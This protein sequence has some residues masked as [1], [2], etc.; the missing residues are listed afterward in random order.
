MHTTHSALSGAQLRS[1]FSGKT[2]L[3]A[4]DSET[5]LLALE[6]RCQ[7][8]GF[9]VEKTTHGLQTLLKVAKGNLDLL[10]LDLNLPDTTGFKVIERLTDP[11]FPP[12][13]VIIL[14]AQTDADT[15]K[16]CEDLGVPYVHK[17]DNAWTELETAIHRVFLER[18][19]DEQCQVPRRKIPHQRQ[20]YCWWTM[21]PLHLSGSRRLCANKT[22]TPSR[23]RAA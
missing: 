9:R 11:K 3:V 18:G 5:M 23:R 2:V 6:T 14:T 10:I 13:P 1:T 7:G 21:I 17:G 20:G 8:L 16:R 4:D 19:E 12:L 15:I 22:S